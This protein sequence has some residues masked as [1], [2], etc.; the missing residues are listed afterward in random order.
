MIRNSPGESGFGAIIATGAC[1]AMIF[2]TLPLFLGAAADAHQLSHAATGGLGSLYLGAFGLSS[3]AA[4]YWMRRADRRVLALGLFIGAVA[5]LAIAA[6]ADGW[7]FF[8]ASV[9][10]AGLLLGALYSLSFVIAGERSNPT[11]A[12]GIKLLGEVAL[13]AALLAVIP[14][15]L[16]PVFGM[17]G[18]LM[19]F[20]AVALAGSLCVPWIARRAPLSSTAQPS[21]ESARPGLP[22]AAVACLAALFV[23]TIGQSALWSFVERRAAAAGFEGAAIGA[24]LS[25]AAFAGGMGSL[26][27]AWISERLGAVTPLLVAALLQAVALILF[28]TVGGFPAFV[29]SVNLFMFAWLFALPYMT[30]AVSASDSNG[31][32]TSL[33]AA[34]LA[35][36]SMVGPG[37]AG[38]LVAG[39]GFGW[40]YAGTAVAAFAAYMAFG[41]LTITRIEPKAGMAD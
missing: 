26:V 19:A 24:A 20:A 9:F 40:L 16:L 4:A 32:A 6:T 17:A 5:M 36:G 3:V 15:Y 35:F 18:M 7:L 12:F 23:F 38:Q 30:A 11:R 1:A 34:C 27:A 21:T 25:V 13:G 29:A 33:V 31:R 41:S 37:V 8:A 2:N 22:M 28:A 39:G 10:G 14:L